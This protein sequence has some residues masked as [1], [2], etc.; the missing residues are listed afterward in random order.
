MSEAPFDGTVAQTDEVEAPPH[1][2]WED[3]KQQHTVSS[4]AVFCCRVGRRRLLRPDSRMVR[5]ACQVGP[6]SLLMVEARR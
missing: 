6:P 1:G 4:V 2:K 5:L 3:G